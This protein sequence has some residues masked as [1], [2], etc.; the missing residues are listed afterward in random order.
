MRNIDSRTGSLR[1]DCCVFL[2]HSFSA[3]TFATQ[4]PHSDQR[5]DIDPRRRRAKADKTTSVVA[6]VRPGPVPMSSDTNF[7]RTEEPRQTRL[8]LSANE[9]LW[10]V[11]A[12]MTVYSAL[13]LAAR[14]T[15][16]HF[17]VSSAMNKSA[18]ESANTA[19]PRS[20]RRCFMSGSARAAFRLDID[21]ELEGSTCHKKP[22][23]SIGFRQTESRS[24]ARPRRSR[25]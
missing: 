9:T 18:A 17:S 23:S 20:L 19:H 3:V 12:T 21:H 13:M 24:G 1:F 15:L 4:S 14:I 25:A 22:C 11:G 7:D 8:A 10:N 16:L 6:H 2:F 5:A